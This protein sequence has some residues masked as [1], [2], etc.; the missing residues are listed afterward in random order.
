MREIDKTY[1]ADVWDAL[2]LG[3]FVIIAWSIIIVIAPI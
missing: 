3:A 2:A 1:K